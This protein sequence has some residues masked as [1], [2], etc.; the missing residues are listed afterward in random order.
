MYCNRDDDIL[1]VSG[2]D[3]F[4]PVKT[5]NMML[6]GGV[7]ITPVTAQASS[8]ISCGGNSAQTCGKLNTEWVTLNVGGK[9]FTTSRSTLTTKEPMSMLAR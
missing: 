4:V 9:Y 5:P 7:S 2:G 3:D 8:D 1:Y 6:M